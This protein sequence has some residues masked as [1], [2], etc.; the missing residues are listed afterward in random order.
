MKI[1]IRRIFIKSNAS[2]FTLIEL[3]LVLVILGVLAA[4]VVPKVSGRTEQARIT[5]A[6]TQV[7]NFGV[8]LDAFEVDNGYYPKGKGGLEDLVIQP[9][10]AQNW[11]GPYI[12]QIPMDPWNNPY[13]YE[14]PGKHNDTSY[15]LMSMG[16]DGRIGGGDDI[17]NY[18]DA[19][20]RR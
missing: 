20:R 17:T 8:A 19:T 12:K 14:A 4:I 18:D 7:S 1:Q 13:I 6:V 9:K 15:D 2:G 3:L 10:D 5:A 11:R 16:P